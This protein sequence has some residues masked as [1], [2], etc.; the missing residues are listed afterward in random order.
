MKKNGLYC[1]HN[2]SRLYQS[3]I[4]SDRKMGYG[5]HRSA[6][7]QNRGAVCGIGEACI[8]TGC[9]DATMTR[10]RWKI[11]KEELDNQGEKYEMDYTTRCKMFKT[12]NGSKV[13]AIFKVAI[14]V[15]VLGKCTF[16]VLDSDDIFT[17]PLIGNRCL[18]GKSILHSFDDGVLYVGG[19][20]VSL[21]DIG[22][23][24]IPLFKTEEQCSVNYLQSRLDLLGCSTV[25]N[26]DV[27]L[28]HCPSIDDNDGE[29][30]FLDESD[31]E[32]SENSAAKSRILFF[33]EDSL[34]FEGVKKL[35]VSQWHANA[36]QLF[37]R[38]S[39]VLD[40]V[41]QTKFK[42]L[43]EEVVKK[44]KVCEKAKPTSGHPKRRGIVAKAFNQL[45]G[46]DHFHFQ[47]N[48]ETVNVPRLMDFYSKYSMCVISNGSAQDVIRGLMKWRNIFGS[49][50]RIFL[51][52]GGPEYAN[53]AVQKFCTSQNIV[54]L[55]TPVTCIPPRATGPWSDTTD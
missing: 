52:D 47:H 45:M 15:P 42:T 44:C 19:R 28:E 13:A 11:V 12:A 49:F 38:Y 41:G 55:R 37:D 30:S 8:D 14:W 32:N 3:I 50:P 18:M 1:W 33:D 26:S 16:S 25:E 39:P 51:S 40:E 35:H 17:P 23:P 4:E 34:D 54:K 36:K 22:V 7:F 27:N 10:G 5:R 20:E 43:A 29:F 6:F 21:R 53:V 46:S 48:G 2:T 31:G 24:L 9:S